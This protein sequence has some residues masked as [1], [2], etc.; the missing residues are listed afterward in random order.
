VAERPDGADRPGGADRPRTADRRETAERHVGAADRFAG[1]CAAVVRRLPGPL[2]RIVAPTFL[3][4][5]LINSTTFAIDLLLLTLLRSGLGL[6]LP[7]AVTLGYVVAFGLAYVLNRW[8]NFRSHAPVGPQTGRYVGVVVVNYVAFILG[9]S[10]GLAALG[11]PYQVAR[12]AAG[13]C[14]AVYMYCAMRW[15]VFA[16]AREPDQKRAS[17][18]V[19]SSAS[20]REN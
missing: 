1:F 12:L 3:G 9:V 17:S 16:Q 20:S 4:F 2:R 18:V 14:E 11:V 10:T 19:R 7:V 5:A 8:L 13:A 15:F 6:P